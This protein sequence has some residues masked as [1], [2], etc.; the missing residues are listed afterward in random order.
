[1]GD[2]RD[3]GRAGAS[4]D[5]DNHNDDIDN[6]NHENDDYDNDNN[7][8]NDNEQEQVAAKQD[9]PNLEDAL[10]KLDKLDLDSDDDMRQKSYTK[11]AAAR[12]EEKPQVV[13]QAPEVESYYPTPLVT[14]GVNGFHNGK[15]EETAEEEEA[16]TS[17]FISEMIDIDDLLM[18]GSHFVALDSSPV[19]FNEEED[20]TPKTHSGDFTNAKPIAD[21]V[22]VRAITTCT[23]ASCLFP[24]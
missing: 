19:F 3:G 11:T 17:T 14:N 20:S 12:K 5:N 13:V 1:M 24:I 7:D 23:Q 15:L 10:D 21:I 6:N 8:A 16:P 18:K 4:N 22:Q 9:E 2:G